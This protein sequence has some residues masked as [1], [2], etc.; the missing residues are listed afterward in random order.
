MT[1]DAKADVRLFAHIDE[2]AD[3]LAKRYPERWD[4][5]SHVVRSALA[6]FKHYLE[7]DEGLTW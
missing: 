4:S 6:H 3:E 7:V 1:L 5:K 2:W